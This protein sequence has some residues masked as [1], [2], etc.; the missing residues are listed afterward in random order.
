VVVGVCA[1]AVLRRDG[2][3]RTLREVADTL[4]LD[5]EILARAYKR[6]V[7]LLG[8]Q[9]PLVDATAFA[10]RA[11]SRL[12][13]D[14]AGAPAVSSVQRRAILD[15]VRR[16]LTLCQHSALWGTGRRPE[17]LVAAA[18]LVAVDAERVERTFPLA[19]V[20]AACDAAPAT[21]NERRIELHKQL[22]AWANAYCTWL[23]RPIKSYKSLVPTLHTLIRQTEMLTQLADMV[24]NGGELIQALFDD[25]DEDAS[26]DARA[27]ASVALATESLPPVSEPPAFTKAVA[28]ND[29]LL[30]LIVRT[31]REMAHEGAPKELLELSDIELPF[32]DDGAKAHLLDMERPLTESEQSTAATLRQLVQARVNVRDMLESAAD[33]ERLLATS[34]GAAARVGRNLDSTVISAADMNDDELADYVLSGAE[35]NEMAHK[36]AKIVE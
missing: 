14:V 15:C 24:E 1:Y 13:F 34:R 35:A 7:S 30:A 33:L 3:A 17:P 8:L 27:L 16:I 2:E 36:R 25:G 29:R 19:T 21:V 28:K 11:V 12:P 9:M 18:M 26:D 6:V 32:I 4:Q 31:K 22:L 5:E 10:E 20:C 23:E